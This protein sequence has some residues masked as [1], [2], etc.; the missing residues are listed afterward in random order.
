MKAG[1]GLHRA[2]L[3]EEVQMECVTTRIVA[4]AELE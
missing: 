1:C 4:H 3:V 2:A